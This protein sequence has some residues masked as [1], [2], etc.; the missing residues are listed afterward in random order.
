MKYSFRF[1]KNFNQKVLEDHNLK[2]VEKNGLKVVVEGSFYDVLQLKNY[3][4]IKDM[5]EYANKS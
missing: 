5:S 4:F 3:P 1:D 2:L